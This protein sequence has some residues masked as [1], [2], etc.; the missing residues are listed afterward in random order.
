MPILRSYQQA[1][2]EW[3]VNR[4]FGLRARILADPPG[5]GKTAQAVVA[6]GMELERSSDESKCAVV[7]CPAIARSDWKRE[8]GLWAPGAKT[9][10]V[11]WDEPTYR[12]RKNGVVESLDSLHDRQDAVLLRALHS[13]TPAFLVSSYESAGRILDL[14]DGMKFPLLTLDE[15]HYIKHEGALRTKAIRPLV[16][17]A[18][19]TY[20]L[21]GT[22]VHNRAF[23]L[24]QLLEICAL[25]RWGSKWTFAHR[26]FNIGYTGFGQVV[27]SLKE[28]EALHAAIQNYVLCHTEEEAFGELP[29]RIRTLQRVRPAEAREYL[30]GLSPVRAKQMATANEGA[31]Q[32]LREAAA[33]KLQAAAD[34][35]RSLEEPVVLYTYKRDHAAELCRRLNAMKVKALLATGDSEPKARS[36]IIERWKLGEAIAL[37]CTL[38]AVQTSATLTRASAMIFADVS[39]VPATQIQCEGRID[40]SRQPEG[41]RRPARY[42]YI[43]LDG[44]YDE[45]I[46]SALS[47]K[48]TEMQGVVSMSA[49][50]DGL[51]RMLG[52]KV[53]PEKSAAEMMA[54]LR[55]RL[56][57]HA[58]RLEAVGGGLL[59][60]WTGDEEEDEA[61]V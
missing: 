57:T 45:V 55:D 43:V 46:I 21:T 32:I 6:A 34:L 58:A 23:D 40:P 24:H 37:V 54:S 52:K 8:V 26:F 7:F 5:Y 13:K 30:L 28:K 61:E 9:T 3:L 42:Y 56:V 33:F 4:P 11:G 38:D 48:I 27:G 59:S 16:G 44:S 18:G 47:D 49:N 29:A 20:L 50:V 19:A 35:A 17:R 12:R 2:A 1:G 36:A 39:V 51:A 22:P 60:G 41:E 31:E 25:G 14:A 53:A 10:I 15:A